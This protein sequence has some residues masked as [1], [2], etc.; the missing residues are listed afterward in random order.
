MPHQTVLTIGLTNIWPNFGFTE[1]SLIS[2]D[3]AVQSI[4]G[5]TDENIWHF[6]VAVRWKK[7]CCFLFWHSTHYDCVLSNFVL[8]GGCWIHSG[9]LEEGR[10]MSNPLMGCPVPKLKKLPPIRS[11]RW[12]QNITFQQRIFNISYDSD[13]WTLL[14]IWLSKQV[15]RWMEV[16]TELENVIWYW[17]WYW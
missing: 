2:S 5:K 14:K 10:R 17:Y 11:L 7:K 9:A 12:N 13:I 6:G 15:D 1:S 16:T 4:N 3:S 8:S